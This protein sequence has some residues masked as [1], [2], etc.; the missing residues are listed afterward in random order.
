MI[1]NKA[2]RKRG[3]DRIL[4]RSRWSGKLFKFCIATGKDL[5]V[6]DDLRNFNGNDKLLRCFRCP[7]FYDLG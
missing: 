3:P 6:G 1:E 4:E 5:I 7:A 2:F